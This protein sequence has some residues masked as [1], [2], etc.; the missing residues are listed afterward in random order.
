MITSDSLMRAMKTPL[1]EKEESTSKDLTDASAP[2]EKTAEGDSTVIQREDSREE[3]PAEPF[4]QEEL[5]HQ[6][7]LHL[8]D[9]NA[10]QRDARKKKLTDLTF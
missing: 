8:E 5:E 9:I 10:K 7:V 2:Q 6:K 3:A 4:T 1:S